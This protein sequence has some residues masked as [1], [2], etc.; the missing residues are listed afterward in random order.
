MRN[1]ANFVCESRFLCTKCYEITVDANE[2]GVK[3]L[4]IVLFCRLVRDDVA[5]Y[6]AVT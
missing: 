4:T 3:M 1:V 2:I 5:D 6:L